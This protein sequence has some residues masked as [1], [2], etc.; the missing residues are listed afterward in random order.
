MWKGLLWPMVVAACLLGPAANAQRESLD[1]ASANIRAAAGGHR[2]I[3]IGEKHGTREIPILVGRLVGAYALEGP[4]LLALEMPASEQPSLRRYL[5]SDGSDAARRML[6]ATP[7]WTVDGDQHDGRR[8]HDMVDLVEHIRKLKSQGQDVSMM[9]Y[10]VERGT[11]RSPNHRDQ[12]MAARVRAAYAALGHGRLL[13]L[14]GNVHAMLEKRDGAPA[15]MPVPMG[16]WLRDLGPWSVDIVARRG[17]FWGCRDGCRAIQI[18]ARLPRT[19]PLMDDVFH[20]REAL[21]LFQ[22]ARLIGAEPS[23]LSTK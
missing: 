4:V 14:G 17:A 13:V 5:A 20:H 19:G 11:P 22:V 15:E 23:P 10:D 1:S 7:F 9:A 6:M 16:Y 21:D 3:L 18:D 2:L 12:A 8:S